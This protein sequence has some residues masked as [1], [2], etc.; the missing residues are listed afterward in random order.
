MTEGVVDFPFDIQGG[1]RPRPPIMEYSAAAAS[2]PDPPTAGEDP[3]PLGSPITLHARTGPH[4]PHFPTDPGPIGRD[5]PEVAIEV[6]IVEEQ[7]LD[8]SVGVHLGERLP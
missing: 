5:A 8:C 2:R 1:N 4:R 3:E 6:E 7:T